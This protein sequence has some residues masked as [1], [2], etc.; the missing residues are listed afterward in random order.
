MTV[1]HTHDSVTNGFAVTSASRCSTRKYLYVGSFKSPSTSC[2][3]NENGLIAPG[4]FSILNIVVCS[5]KLTNLYYSLVYYSLSVCR[6]RCLHSY[7]AKLTSLEYI[8]ELI[9]RNLNPQVNSK[10]EFIL[11]KIEAPTNI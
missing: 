10:N 5:E 2:E 4:C 1:I 11:F 7:Q 8:N 3:E 9:I 6:H